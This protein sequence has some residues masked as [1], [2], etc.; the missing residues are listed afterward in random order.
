MAAADTTGA[1]AI[2]IELYV[3]HCLR[4]GTLAQRVLRVLNHYDMP[5]SERL[6]GLHKSVDHPVTLAR[7]GDLSLRSMQRDLKPIGLIPPRQLVIAQLP[8]VS[9][10]QVSL[11]EQRKD[12]V[13]VDFGF[14]VLRQ[15]L[16]GCTEVDLQPA[17]QLQPVV[18][19]QHMGN[20]A[21]A[22][23]T[24]DP[25]HFLIRATDV[26]RINR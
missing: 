2:D 16:H 1:L 25:N 22:R 4:V 19:T 17:R 13:A 24:I 20:T 5:A 23:L 3:T 21:L 18:S 9:G 15:A 6:H 12:I 26:G 14:A 10:A 11:A 7:Q 8:S